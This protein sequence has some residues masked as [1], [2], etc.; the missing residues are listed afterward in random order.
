VEKEVLPALIRGMSY[1]GMRVS[2]GTEACLA[3]QEMIGGNA[4]A[5]RRVTLRAALRKYCQQDT[6]AMAKLLEVLN[7]TS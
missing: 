6:L 4:N 3:W 7:A 5:A 1:Q 2:E